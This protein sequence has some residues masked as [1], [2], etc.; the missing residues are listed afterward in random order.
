[1]KVKLAATQMNCSWEI[2]NNISKAKQLINTAAKK[3]ANVILIQE[4]FQTP[5]FGI[6]YDEKIFRLAK[7]F[8]DNPVI[9]EMSELAK[10]LNVVL[11]ISYFEV[12]NNAYYNSI[13]I[14]TADGKIRNCLYSDEEFDLKKLLRS[15]RS[16]KD[17]ERV[18]RKAM[19]LK[20]EDGWFA[21][22][23]K[24]R[25]RESMTQIGG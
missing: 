1:M 10:K 17:I 8:K 6:E 21:Q 18:I 4:L 13:A 22:K 3:G 23:G 9:N 24:E 15:I 7:P 20:P 12:E 14:I 19:R 5:Y 2:K 25:H 11:P 16:D